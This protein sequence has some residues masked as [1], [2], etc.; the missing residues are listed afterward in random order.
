VAVTQLPVDSA[1]IT[2]VLVY[3]GGRRLVVV[4][5]YIPDLCAR[6]TKE[7]NLGELNSRLE[8]IKELGQ[9]ELI[10]NSR[11][12]IIVASDFNRHSSL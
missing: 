6:R 3:I 11:T 9:R 10:H 12:E 1:D 7:E 4:S 2:A 5:V 8:K